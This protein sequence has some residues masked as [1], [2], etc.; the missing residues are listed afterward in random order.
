MRSRIRLLVAALA[1]ALIA[2]VLL[3][4]PA[5]VAKPTGGDGEPVKVVR[6]LGEQRLPFGLQF[7]GTT[8]GGLSGIDFDPDSGTW[9]VISD[10][11]SEH[12]PA[13]FYTASLDFA[14]D[15]TLEGVTVT[16]VTTLQQPDGT[17]FPELGVDPEAIRY[18]AETGTLLWSSEGERDLEAADGPKLIDPF[19]RETGTDGAHQDELQ[20]PA[21]LQ[22]QAEDRG[23]RQNQALEAL[24]L[25]ADGDEVIAAMEGP[26]FQDG[27]AA[28]PENGSI[29]R[30]TVLD[31]DSGKPVAQYAYPLD[32]MPDAPVPPSTTGNNGAVEILAV[33]DDRYLVME[34]AFASGVGL[35]VR[36]FEIDTS[37]AT[38]VLGKKSLA[39]QTGYKPVTKRLVANLADVGVT[40]VGNVEGMTWGPKGTNGERTLVLVSDDNFGQGQIMQFLAF[41]V[42][43]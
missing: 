43:A 33:D 9:Y 12:G 8:V 41:E 3:T 1:T 27:P 23:P 35:S 36:I 17:P 26:L 38:N 14:D 18:D 16:G 25:S 22:M 19:V 6:F 24:T 7:E 28:T 15:L 30:F 10:D 21:H 2:G 13:R 39:D 40:E 37:K 34:R 29:N 5:V 42:N 32:P 11:R 4:A 31:R 20:L